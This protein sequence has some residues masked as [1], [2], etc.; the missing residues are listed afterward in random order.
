MLAGDRGLVYVFQIWRAFDV[1]FTNNG[2]PPNLKDVSQT[3]D[4]TTMG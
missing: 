3:P 4:G 2:E 1:E